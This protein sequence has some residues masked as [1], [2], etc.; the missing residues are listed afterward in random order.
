MAKKVLIKKNDE[1]KK[2]IP[3]KPIQLAEVRVT[4]SRVKPKPSRDSVTYRGSSLTVPRFKEKPEKIAIKDLAK[5]EGKIPWASGN[6]KNA[7]SIKDSTLR[8]RSAQ[9]ALDAYRIEGGS[10]DAVVRQYKK[11]KQKK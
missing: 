1:V 6:F 8:Q 2:A 4:A 7:N 9:G 3:K 11:D 5:A 10:R